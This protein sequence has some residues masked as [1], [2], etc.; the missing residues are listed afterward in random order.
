MRFQRES[1]NLGSDCRRPVR[2]Q[3]DKPG[4][5]PVLDHFFGP[6][7]QTRQAPPIATI[8][9][10]EPTVTATATSILSRKLQHMFRLL[11]N[12]QDG[13]VTAQDISARA[14]A[15]AAPFG[16]H[17]EKA[18]ALKDSMHHI[19]D[20]YLQQVDEDGDGRLTAADY[21]RGIR[22]AIDGDNAGFVDSLHRSAAAWY[23]LFEADRDGHLNFDEYA[24]LARGMGGAAAEGREQA[25]RRLDHDA[26]G[27]LRAEEVRKAVVEF[28]TGEDPDANGNWLYGPL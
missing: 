25:F 4:G 18:Q 9:R 27:S 22:A 13:Y 5:H 2:A 12:D 14:D 10:G 17:P 23:A 1:P 28:W 11:D 6:V 26:D 7:P 24:T 8:R 19:W 15:L 16:A 21:E 3:F 20:T